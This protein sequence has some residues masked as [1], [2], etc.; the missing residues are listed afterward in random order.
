MVSIIKATGKDFQ[1][2][3]EIGKVSFF[4]S[5]RTSA[6]KETL[7]IYINK[8]FTED[9]IK[10][11]LA[12]TN[13]L[14]HI[15][16]YNN[17]PA[18]YSKVIL[19]SNHTNIK[20]ENVTKLERIYLLKEFYGLKLGYQLFEFNVNLSKK[21][22][23]NGMWLFVWVENKRAVNFYEKTGFKIIGSHDFFLSKTHSNPNHQ[24]FFKY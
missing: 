15:I 18:G 6:T 7:D 4:E 21:N 11:E 14:F 17:K 9:I 22:K 10:E 24:M 5:H 1:T 23:Q 16:Y 12:D 13:N 19:N 20:Y 8:K 2:I 3:T